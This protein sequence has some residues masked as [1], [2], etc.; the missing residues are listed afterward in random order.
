MR[1]AGQQVQTSA[2]RRP[3]PSV[4]AV[5][6][7]IPRQ[8]RGAHNVS[9]IGAA[10]RYAAAAPT[11]SGADMH[12]ESNRD[13]LPQTREENPHMRAA[14]YVRLSKEDLE[15]VALVLRPLRLSNDRRPHGEQW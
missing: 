8:L 5:A 1:A 4:M 15:G 11:L 6:A 2:A 7:P 13:V 9:T 12:R 10:P 3:N 14:V